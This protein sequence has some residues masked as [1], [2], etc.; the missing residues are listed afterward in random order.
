MGGDS[1]TYA[2]KDVPSV[3]KDLS[4]FSGFSSGST[5]RARLAMVAY[6]SL[7]RWMVISLWSE[8]VVGESY[9]ERGNSI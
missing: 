5:S 9:Q 6:S 1:L 3:S 4:I 7:G 8:R 2:I